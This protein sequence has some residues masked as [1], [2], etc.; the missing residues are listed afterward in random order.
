[1]LLFCILNV[2]VCF[3]LVFVFFFSN[4]KRETSRM[5]LCLLHRVRFYGEWI[6]F[7]ISY[8]NNTRQPYRLILTKMFSIRNSSQNNSVTTF[9]VCCLIVFLWC[10]S[11]QQL[12]ASSK[13]CLFLLIL[14]ACHF[15]SKYIFVNWKMIK[16]S[17][18]A[19]FFKESKSFSIT[20]NTVCF[21]KMFLD[22]NALHSYVGM[23]RQ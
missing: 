16:F 6:F 10:P 8:D 23:R 9:E 4:I 19:R 18:F 22:L 13:W 21:E 12:F 17:Y 1:M 3:Q 11:L 7:L 20:K 2:K 14:T 5:T 15:I